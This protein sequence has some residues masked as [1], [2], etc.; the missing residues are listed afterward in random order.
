MLFVL[1][2]VPHQLL[3]QQILLARKILDPILSGPPIAHT[4]LDV[5]AIG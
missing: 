1:V 3:I 5:Q 4:Q 2:K